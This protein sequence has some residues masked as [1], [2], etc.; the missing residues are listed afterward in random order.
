MARS[1]K[2]IMTNEE[3]IDLVKSGVY[4]I[5]TETGE[6][7]SR[8]GRTVSH[9]R[10]MGCGKYLFVRLYSNKNRKAIAVHR[11][12]WMSVTMTPIPHGWQVHHLS[13]DTM[14]NTWDNLVCLHKK[15][16][17]KMHRVEDEEPVPF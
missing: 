13:K 15:D 17:D 5:D 6:V 1:Y 7:K 2:R 14:D 11:L 9:V 8:R 3:V 4:V 12:V 10:S 16:H